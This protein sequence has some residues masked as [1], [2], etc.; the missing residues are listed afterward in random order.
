MF[1]IKHLVVVVVLGALVSFCSSASLATPVYPSGCFFD[2]QKDTHGVNTFI[3][4]VIVLF[5]CL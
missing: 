2:V 5:I 3:C 4:C 1:G